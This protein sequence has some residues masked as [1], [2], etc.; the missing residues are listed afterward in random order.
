MRTSGFHALIV[1]GALLGASGVVDAAELLPARYFY[2]ETTGGGLNPGVLV[3]FNPQPDPP[4][5]PL[6]SLDLSDSRRPL[7]DQPSGNSYIV[8]VSLFPGTPS[9]LLPAVQAPNSDGQTQACDGSVRTCDGSVFKLSLAFQGVGGVQDWAA[10]NP[11]PLP[12]GGPDFLGEY[13]SYQ[14]TFAGDATFALSITEN[15]DS[16]SFRSVPEP[17]TWALMGLGFASIGSL[18]AFA[19][20]QKAGRKDLDA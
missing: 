6:T 17:A 1:A 11:Q 2:F 12:P 7:F 8:F 4:G 5:A 13:L 16:L 20:R 14:I 9:L 3:G 15:G 19:R 10:L 18:A